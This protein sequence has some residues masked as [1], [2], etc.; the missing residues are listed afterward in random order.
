[1]TAHVAAPHFE[2]E[3]RY[4]LLEEELAQRELA[5][6]RKR[7]WLRFRI[8]SLNLYPPADWEK[9]LKAL[10]DYRRHLAGHE[11]EIKEGLI[12]L[13]LRATSDSSEDDAHIDIHLSVQHGAFRPKKKPPQRP[14]RMDGAVNAAG[15]PHWR[16]PEPGGFAR[17]HLRIGSRKLDVEFSR[18]PAY[19][20]ALIVH[21][22]LYIETSK[23]TTLHYSVRSRNHPDELS[24]TI[25][26]PKHTKFS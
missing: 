7:L 21:Q 26:L 16:F 18:L 13:H 15:K 5:A 4:V 9:Y 11:K 14:P 2:A 10:D 1:M 17:R 12:P 24:G 3:R 6:A 25:R 8:G 22:A 20:S 19:D 23:E